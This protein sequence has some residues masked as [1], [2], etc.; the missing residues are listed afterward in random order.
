MRPLISYYGG[1]QRL[2]KWIISHFPLHTSYI[3]PFCGGASVFFAKELAAVNVLNDTNGMVVNL[4]RQAKLHPEELFRMI[5]ATPHSRSEYNRAAAIYKSKTPATDLEKAWAMHTAT[6]Q[7]FAKKTACGWAFEKGFEEAKT[8]NSVANQKKTIRAI[9]NHLNKS[10]IDSIDAIK[11]IERYDQKEALFYIDPP[12]V[13]TQQGPYSGYQQADFDRLLEV[14]KTIKG[15]FFLSHYANQSMSDY[16]AANGWMVN[17]KETRCHAT[18]VRGD[19]AKRTEILV[20][21][22]VPET[23]FTA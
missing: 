5:D 2:S 23:L 10:Q 7:A 19:L 15:T 6:M 12:Y 18:M 8:T 3:E 14:L 11:C 21:N 1:K 4:Y 22:Y 13:G 9:I 20:T 16:A 17:E